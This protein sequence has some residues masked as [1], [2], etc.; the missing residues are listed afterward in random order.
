MARITR[1]ML[2]LL[3]AAS[4]ILALGAAPAFAASVPVWINN[5]KATIFTASGETGSLPAGTSVTMT[6]TKSGWARIDYN[7]NTGY[8]RTKYLT[9]V[10]GITGYVTKRVPVYKSASTSS[11][12]YGPLSVGTELKVV[13]INGSFYQVTNGK[14][15]GYIQKSAISRTKPSTSTVI[16]SKV[17]AVD[18][19]TGNR[20]ISK[21]AYVAIYDIMTGTTF[22]ARRLGGSQHADFEPATVEDTQKMLKIGGGKFSWNSRPVI[23]RVGKTYI[24]AAINTMPH[25]ASS[26][27]ENLFDGQFCVHLPGSKTHETN[28]ENANHQ[29][30]IKYAYAWALTK[31]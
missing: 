23:L 11:A 1:S 10:D 14:H 6:A 19:S 2:C 13:G 31:Q 27:S 5:S 8:V 16:A 20:L 7:G 26:I 15:Y 18:W 25:G 17:Q 28:V 30:A 9:L 12:K 3:L 4:L 29:A 21:G 22:R 24:A